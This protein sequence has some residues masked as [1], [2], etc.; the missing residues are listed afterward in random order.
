MLAM[1]DAG[2]AGIDAP[3]RLRSGEIAIHGR[4]GGSSEDR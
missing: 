2:V 4:H 3:G 1:P